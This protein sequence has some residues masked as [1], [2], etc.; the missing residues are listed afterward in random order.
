MLCLLFKSSFSTVILYNKQ[1]QNLFHAYGQSNSLDS[2]LWVKIAFPHDFRSLSEGIMALWGRFFWCW[3]VEVLENC[4]NL[5]D[6]LKPKR[7]MVYCHFSVFISLVRE[8]CL[9]SK[10]HCTILH[11]RV[12]IWFCSSKRVK[13][14]K[15]L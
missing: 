1:L 13:G 2:R 5:P 14:W 3:V 7:R 12:W 10:R 4:G 6:L 15:K 9:P 8:L 11:S